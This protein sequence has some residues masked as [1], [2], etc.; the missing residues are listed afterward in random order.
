MTS[1][2]GKSILVTGGASGIG[3]ATCA[4]L[5]ERG[6][7]VA[8]WD[9]TPDGVER[10]A[11]EL[12]PTGERCRG[13][14]V[15]VS[16]AAPVERA[17]AATLKAFGSIHGA[18]NNAGIGGPTRP[19]GDLE[20][21]DFDRIVAV[22]LKGVWLCLRQELR[23]LAA[24][25]GSIVNNASVAGQVGLAGQG[26]YT[27]AKH[28]VVGLSKAAAIEYAAAG[29]R[30]NCVCPGAVRTPILSHLEQAGID[31]KALAA[32]CPAGRIAAPAEVAA[33]VAWLLSEEA[34]F[35]TGAALSVDGGWTAQ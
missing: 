12:D 34:S 31:E 9:N 7:S 19:L 1:F 27:A 8:L 20:E 6:A 3:R 24:G 18:F 35:V 21:D 26:A 30:V 28:G 4:L 29:I 10:A 32:M 13:F 2:A 14:A 11:R 5:L 22:D 25:R 16:S 17:M 23:A 33:A 15:D